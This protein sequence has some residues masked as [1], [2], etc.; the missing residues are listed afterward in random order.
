MSLDAIATTSSFE[1]QSH[2]SPRDVLSI[3][4]EQRF[5]SVNNRPSHCVVPSSSAP[6]QASRKLL[7][8]RK[9]RGNIGWC[10]DGSVLTNNVNDVAPVTSDDDVFNSLTVQAHDWMHGQEYNVRIEH[11]DLDRSVNNGGPRVSLVRVHVRPMEDLPTNR[12]AV[13]GTDPPAESLVLREA[14]VY[15]DLKS[16]VFEN[17]VFCACYCYMCFFVCDVYIY[18]E[19]IAHTAHTTHSYALLMHRHLLFSTNAECN[20]TLFQ[21]SCGY[22]WWN[23]TLRNYMESQE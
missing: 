22:L 23:I 19:L 20:S 1:H 15:V 11:V 3:L 14:K 13:W 18:D 8:L 7:Y 10:C 9:T 2:D 12:K 16:I 4:Q 5:F 17:V 6:Q 21:P